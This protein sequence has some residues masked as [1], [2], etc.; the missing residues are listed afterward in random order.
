M[1]SVFLL[2]GSGFLGKRVIP[3]LLAAGYKVRGVARSPA[4]RMVVRSLGADPI[5]ANLDDRSQIVRA[6]ASE[7]HDVFL[8]LISLGLGH[9][10]TLV[11]AAE[12]SGAKRAVFVSSASVTT[13]LPSV[14]RP[15]R[16]AAEATI[17][18]SSL[19]WT[20]LRPTMIYGAPDD[21][22]FAR[23]LRLLARSPVVVVPGSGKALQQ[24]IHVDDLAEGIVAALG[25]RDTVG[26]TYNLAGP[27]PQDLNTI[28]RI[29]SDAVGRRARI[30][31]VPAGPALWM[32]R[33]YELWSPNP[34]LRAEQVARLAED[35]SL[36][37]HDARRDFR[38]CPRSFEDGILAEAFQV[39]GFADE[40]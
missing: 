15:I 3:E 27:D 33:A 23:L 22:N 8:S 34:R 20:I 13:S 21:R 10:A 11:N 14:S 29:A 35:K 40:S 32:V 17:K 16:A 26:K 1:T 2:G 4:A 19:A 12:A 5:D 25:A 36:S 31:H 38:F 39:L 24:P 28:I 7:T 6:A 9:A 18:D 30:W 37:I